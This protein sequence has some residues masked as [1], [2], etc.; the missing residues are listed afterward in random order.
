M[1]DTP[2]QVPATPAT[3]TPVSAATTPAEAPKVT[4]PPPDQMTYDQARLLI[5]N[6]DTVNIYRPSGFHLKTPLYSLISFMTGSPIYHCVTAIWMRSPNG[7][8]RLMCVEANLLGGK[9]IVPL[10]I[11]MVRKMEVM[12][13]PTAYDFS[14]MEDGL[15]ARVAVES[16]GLLDFITIGLREFFGIKRAAAHISKGQVCSELCSDAWIAAGFP[17]AETVVSP[18]KL[19]AEMVAAGVMPTIVIPAVSTIEV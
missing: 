2:E 11:Y 19:K 18:G 7:T 14:K 5:K 16:Y 4:L 12:P 3:A 17:F 10:S 1:A 13:L 6:G 9:R 15:M 8:P